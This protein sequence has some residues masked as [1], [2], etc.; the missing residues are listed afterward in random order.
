MIMLPNPKAAD[1]V[2]PP[3][4]ANPTKKWI[5]LRLHRENVFNEFYELPLLIPVA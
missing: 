4:T 2:I 1:P 3:H 5:L